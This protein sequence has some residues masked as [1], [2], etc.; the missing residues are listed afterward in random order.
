M[1]ARCNIRYILRPGCVMHR[2]DSPAKFTQCACTWGE[3]QLMGEVNDRMMITSSRKKEGMVARIRVLLNSLNARSSRVAFGRSNPHPCAK[4][5]VQ[6]VA[7][8]LVS[9][10]CREFHGQ[11][12]V[13]RSATVPVPDGFVDVA[14]FFSGSYILQG[15]LQGSLLYESKDPLMW[16]VQRTPSCGVSN[17]FF[18]AFFCCVFFY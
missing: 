17:L 2:A 9:G 12:S 4:A 5:C 1:G 18:T 6:C 14:R 16:S 10:L 11:P 13:G 15:V 8:M 7:G 3:Q